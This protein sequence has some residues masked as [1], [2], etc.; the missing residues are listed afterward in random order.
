MRQIDRMYLSRSSSLRLIATA[1]SR[2]LT[3]LVAEEMDLRH[4]YLV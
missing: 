4:L 3:K 1:S 2:S